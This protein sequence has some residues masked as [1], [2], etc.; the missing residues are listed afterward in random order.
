[1]L[2]QKLT[3]AM[4]PFNCLCSAPPTRTIDSAGRSGIHW[5]LCADVAAIDVFAF[6]LTLFEMASQTR[7]WSHLRHLPMHEVFRSVVLKILGSI[8][9]IFP[10]NE[11]QYF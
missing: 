1:M 9:L 10:F 11:M 5:Q 8:R 7:P 2:K 3:R 4:G 6:G